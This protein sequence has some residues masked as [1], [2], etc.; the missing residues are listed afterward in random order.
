[1]SLNPAPFASAGSVAEA[2]NYLNEDLE[3]YDD[4]DERDF[5]VSRYGRGIVGDSNSP[6]DS[7]LGE[8][9]PRIVEASQPT[10]EDVREVAGLHNLGGPCIVISEQA[11]T[12]LLVLATEVV[13][14]RQQLSAQVELVRRFRQFYREHRRSAEFRRRQLVAN[15]QQYAIDCDEFRFI[16]HEVN[17]LLVAAREPLNAQADHPIRRET[18]AQARRIW[19]DME[20]EVALP[21]QLN[22][23]REWRAARLWLWDDE[24]TVDEDT[25]KGRSP[26]ASADRTHLNIHLNIHEWLE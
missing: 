15:L 8:N 5:G 19:R 4:N 25:L 3:D 21:A 12:R 22:N 6:F 2:G 10:N 7:D 11:E 1:M 26:A 24:V 18:V 23:C 17:A 13:G 9:E 16:A 14:L 20:T